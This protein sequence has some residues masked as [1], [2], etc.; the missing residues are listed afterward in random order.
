MIIIRHSQQFFV[1]LTN[2]SYQNI[3]FFRKLL[4]KLKLD[5]KQFTF[6]FASLLSV[7]SSLHNCNTMC[8]CEKTMK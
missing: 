2:S 4:L 6:P 8:L 1:T 3:V 5:L 7:V